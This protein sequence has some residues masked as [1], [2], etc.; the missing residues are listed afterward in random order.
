MVKVFFGCSMSGGYSV[1]SQEELRKF[2]DL[3]EE[4]GHELASKH[5][6][7]KGIFQEEDKLTTTHIHDR[8]YEWLIESDVGVFEITNGS[9]GTGQE[10]SDMIGLGKPVLCLYKK[11]LEY[12]VSAYGRGKQG[13]KYVKTP[14]ECYAYET[15]DDA[16]HKIKEFLESNS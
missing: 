4:L 11:A 5:Q 14:F 2:P 12:N 6:T 9:I 16:K 7:K 8:D 10:I 15:L 13:S 1:L 3:I